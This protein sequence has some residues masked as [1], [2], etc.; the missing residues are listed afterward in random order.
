MAGPTASGIQELID[1][2]PAA[3]WDDSTNTIKN[4]RFGGR[5]SPRVF[6][7]PLYD[8]IYYDSGVRNGRTADLKVANW[9]GYFAESVS[10][11]SIYGR[12]SPIGGIRDMSHPFP[13]GL[14]PKNLRLVQ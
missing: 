3:Y 8:P 12:I 5:Q 9:I 6:P 10:G 13:E 2:D 14:N 1:K 7:I 11:Y 4:S